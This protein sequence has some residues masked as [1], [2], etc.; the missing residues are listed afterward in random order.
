MEH[1]SKPEQPE[2]MPQTL[3]GGIPTPFLYGDEGPSER[4]ALQTI[5]VEKGRQP[6]SAER[7]ALRKSLRR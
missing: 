2:P 1:F 7:R 4:L 6:S 5:C 3:C